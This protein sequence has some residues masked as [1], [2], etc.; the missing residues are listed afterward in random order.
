MYYSDYE[1]KIEFK[2]RYLKIIDELL[3]E[4]YEIIHPLNE[5]SNDLEIDKIIKS[6]EEKGYLEC[7]DE[8]VRYIE[9]NNKH[10]KSNL[11]NKVLRIT[12]GDQGFLN[13]YVIPYILK[14][15][16]WGYYYTDIES[17]I[18]ESGIYF[19]DKIFEVLLR[20]VYSRFIKMDLLYEVKN[21]LEIISLSYAKNKSSVYIK[22]NL[23]LLIEMHKIWIGE[24]VIK[25]LKQFKLTKSEI[26]DFSDFV[27]LQLDVRSKKSKI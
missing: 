6:V 8:I 19:D 10:Y 11:I 17:I 15:S 23:E 20:N 2:K 14:N 18:K 21:D 5:E 27:E 25:I 4:E 3:N 12:N 22:N 24:P 26:N 13:E 16:S 7:I 1:T 9:S